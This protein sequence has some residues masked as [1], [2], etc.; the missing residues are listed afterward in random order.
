MLHLT[1][2]YELAYTYIARCKEE[3]RIFMP[4]ED[5]KSEGNML[6]N[7]QYDEFGN[8]QTIYIGEVGKA[9]YSNIDFE[10][11]LEV[12]NEFT[13]DQSS[14]VENDL[15]NSSVLEENQTAEVDEKSLE[16]RKLTR[17][18]RRLAFYPNVLS[19]P[20]CEGEIKGELCIF[21]VISKRGNRVRILKEQGLDWVQIDDI[22]SLTIK[23]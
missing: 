1:K 21:Q 10:E 5:K 11:I 17:L 9:S 6:I 13:V 4:K 15:E 2:N 16:K 18:I 20:I 19:R 23:E 8:M 14:E 3:R 7:K 22:K 12:D